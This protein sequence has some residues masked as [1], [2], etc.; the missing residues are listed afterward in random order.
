MLSEEEVQEIWIHCPFIRILTIGYR[1]RSIVI[2]N[3]THGKI[4]PTQKSYACKNH[5]H[6]KIICREKSYAQKIIRTEKSYAQKIIRPEKS[7]AQKN[8][9]RKIREISY[10]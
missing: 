9:T 5:T 10:A 2:E 7:Y 6:R 3:H 1:N 4:I 8:H